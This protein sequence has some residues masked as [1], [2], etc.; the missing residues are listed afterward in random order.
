LFE[1]GGFN[2][3]DALNKV[4]QQGFAKKLNLTHKILAKILYDRS[5]LPGWVPIRQ[6][7]NRPTLC[8]TPN[9]RKMQ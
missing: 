8:T 6:I 9:L 5:A 7:D 4:I 3:V 1:N 2:L